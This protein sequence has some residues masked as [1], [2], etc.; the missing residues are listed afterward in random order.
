MKT[1]LTSARRPARARRQRGVVL[2]IALIAMVVLSL[3]GVALIRSV[4][5]AGSVAGNIAF[6]EASTTAVNL[7]VEQAVNWVFVTGFNFEVDNAPFHYFAKLQAGE[8]PNGIPTVLSGTYTMMKGTYPFGAADI[9]PSTKIEVR[10]VIERVCNS[11]APIPM[12]F[13]Q[14][15]QYCDQLPPKV[16]VAKTTGELK[17]PTLPPIP[18]YRVTVRVDVPGTNTTTYAQAML[19]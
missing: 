16:S 15:V 8:K 12:T 13:I 6:R 14:K 18:L 19:R 9:Y 2:F 17:G 7:A 4:D 11:A 1:K 5:T 3:A 10:S